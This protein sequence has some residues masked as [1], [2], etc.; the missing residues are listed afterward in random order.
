MSNILIAIEGIDGSGKTT[1]ARYV[2]DF[3]RSKG[4]STFLLESGKLPKDSIVSQIKQITHNPS[5]KDL[6]YK[7]ETLLY[8]ARLAQR[9]VEYIVPALQEN[10]IVIVDR[11]IM[12]VLV[13]ACYGRNQDKSVLSNMIKFAIGDIDFDFLILCDINEDNAVKRIYGKNEPL[14]RKELEGKKYA[15]KFLLENIAKKLDFQEFILI[16]LDMDLPRT[17]ADHE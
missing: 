17:S 5:N 16:S 8:L 3:L 12:S 15:V 1:V 4:I 10:K 13:L 2:N 14:S 7:T 9:T 11:F 6:T